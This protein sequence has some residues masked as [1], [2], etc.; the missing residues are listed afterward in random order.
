MEDRPAEPDA[1]PRWLDA[2]DKAAW[3]GV[4]SMIMLLP[5]RLEAPLQREHGLSLFE[6]LTLSH[7]SEAPE[8]R[9]RMGELAFLTN[10]SQ[11]RLSNVVKRLE[12]RGWVRRSPDPG[13]GRYT[14]AALTDDGLAVVR[15]AAPTHLRTVRELVLD[16]LGDDDRAVLGRITD[17]LALAFPRP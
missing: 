4:A 13:D 15:A 5:G 9:L 10:G 2:Q 1:A 14:L 3:T 6:Y 16:R 11:S 17:T 8:R 12:G 7:M